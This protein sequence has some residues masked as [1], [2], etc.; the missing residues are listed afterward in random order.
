MCWIRNVFLVVTCEWNYDMTFVVCFLVVM[1]F[2]NYRFLDS[3][4]I[5]GGS[6]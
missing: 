4:V 3:E 6:V 1:R 5:V 2:L